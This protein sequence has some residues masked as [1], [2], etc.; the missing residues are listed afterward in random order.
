MASVGSMTNPDRRVT[1]RPTIRWA[2]AT[3]HP[4]STAGCPTGPWGPVPFGTPGHKQRLD[5]VGPVVRDDIPLYGGVDTIRQQAGAI[6]EA[7]RRLARAWGADWGRIS[8][9]GLDARQP[10][11]DAGAL[12]ARRH[13]GGHPH[14]A[15]LAAAGDGAGRCHAGV[16]APRR[17]PDDRSADPRPGRAGASRRCPRT[18]RPRR[19][20]SSSRPTSAPSPTSPRTPTSCT[21]TASPSSSTRRGVRTSDST[22]TCRGTRSR[23]ERTHSSPARTRRCRPTRRPRSCWHAPSGSTRT[24]STGRSTPPR[25]PARP[26]RSPPARTPPAR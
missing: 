1:T 22:L 12:P 7:D 14:P 5:L 13:R 26:A 9:G 8:V 21:R 4:C 24:G 25:P 17:R 6:A 11:A 19:S 10:D 16:G 18:R 2:C 3:T 23:R 20:S 15:P